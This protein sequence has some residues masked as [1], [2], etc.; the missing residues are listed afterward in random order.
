[1]FVFWDAYDS[2]NFFRVKQYLIPKIL[3]WKAFYTI[4]HIVYSSK[5]KV[6]SKYLSVSFTL[7]EI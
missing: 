1:M 7:A 3:R 4:I 6:V 2:V 5:S